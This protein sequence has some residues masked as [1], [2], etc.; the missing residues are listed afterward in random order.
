MSE[1]LATE[2]IVEDYLKP[3][4][5]VEVRSR[6][7]G[8]WSRGFEVAQVLDHAY[9]LK[10]MSDGSVLPTDFEEQDVRHERRR[11]GMWWA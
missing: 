3:G 10:R 8:R 9:K 1:L 11:Q 2:V 7:D 5:R 6:F 4:T